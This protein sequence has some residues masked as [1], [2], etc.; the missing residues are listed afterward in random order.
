M[1]LANLSDKPATYDTALVEDMK[2]LA[3]THGETVPGTLL[4]LEAVVFGS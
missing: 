3:G 2:L 1:V 4:P